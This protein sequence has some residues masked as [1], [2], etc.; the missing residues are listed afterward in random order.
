MRR[1]LSLLCL[2]AAV[3]GLS[4]CGKQDPDSAA[5]GATAQSYDLIIRG[6]MVYD[7]TGGPA[8]AADIGVQDDRVA[9]VGDLSGASAA[10]EVDAEG[11]AVAPGFI[12]MLSWS[13]TSLFADPRAMSDI[14]QGVTLEVMGEGTSMGP[15][16]EEMRAQIIE[17]Q[18]DFTFDVSWTTLGEYL[19]TLE[20]QG[21]SV[22]VASFIGHATV[23]ENILGFD[24]VQPTPEQQ[25]R[26]DALVRTAMEEG[27]LGVGSSLIYTPATYA[28]TEELISLATVA[29]EYGGGYT[30]H[31]RSEA[32][33]FLEGIEETIRIAR[34]SG[35]WGHI[36]H[37]KPAGISNWDKHADGIRLIEE[38]RADGLDMTVDIYTYTAGATGLDAAFPDWS[39]EG[40]LEAWIAR[41]QDPVLRARIAREMADPNAG[42][43]NLYLQS[44]GGENVVLLG[45]N[46][47]DLRDLTGKTL[48]EVAALRGTNE[49]DTM[50]D[51]VIEDA[52][53]VETAYFLMSEDNIKANIAWPYMMF[54]SDAA[55]M[56]PEPPF[57]SRN[58]HPRAYGT[59]AR[60]LG[61]YVRDEKVISLEEA[62]RRLTSLSAETL[63]LKDRGCLDPGCYA[64]LVVF[65]PD[66]VQD[67]STFDDPHQYSLGVYHVAVNGEL[68]LRDGAHTGVFS[69]RF[70]KGPGYKGER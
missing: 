56:S 16:N 67:L 36:Y 44:G 41:L 6:G 9:F 33:N 63:R 21:T 26:M 62:I 58:P 20:D 5:Q 32:D 48:A 66:E 35:A 11:R 25:E 50:I 27:A 22:N 34:E 39:E 19:Q 29:A 45:F 38:A 65:D 4:A 18:V 13:T 69:G 64:D 51:L 49:I 60:L 37:F 8:Y 7:G 53:W 47:P 10:E 43:E 23:R 46:N 30:T 40:G 42:Y 1:P 14:K 2:S 54:G 61:K 24:D 12:N 28:S 55:A 3:M 52:G 68:V 17:G 57:L 59:F 31:M 15:L 70:V